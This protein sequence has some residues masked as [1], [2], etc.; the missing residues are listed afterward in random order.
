MTAGDE[1]CLLGTAVTEVE[2]KVVDVYCANF[3]VGL[4]ECVG[5]VASD[6]LEKSVDKIE[7]IEIWELA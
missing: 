5:N 2:A 1:I 6:A 4:A 3:F 7:K